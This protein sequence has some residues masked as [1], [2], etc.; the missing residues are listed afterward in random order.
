MVEK[1][2]ISTEVGDTITAMFNPERY[3]VTKGVQFAEIG[4]P[5]LDSPVLQFVRGQNEKVTMEL[6]FDT[7]DKGMVGD[8]TD[9]RTKSGKVYQL[10]KINPDTHAPPRIL[11]SWGDDNQIFSYGSSVSPWCVIENLN[12]E[13]TLFAPNG[14]PLRSKLTVTFREAWTVEEQLQASGRHS[15]DRTSVRRVQR[16]QTLSYI[17]Y[18]AYNDAANWRPIADA[19]KIDN[20]RL[21]KAGAMLTIPSNPSEKR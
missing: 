4:I 15:T 13:F 6:F 10:M 1:V 17:A 7:T 19:N 14:I 9:V 16:G 5:G 18:L 2:T 21:L 3:T 8:V 20:P 12:E 11:V